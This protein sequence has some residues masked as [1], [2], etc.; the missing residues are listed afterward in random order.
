MLKAGSVQ[1]GEHTAMIEDFVKY[2]PS[3]LQHKSGMVFY[4]GRTAFSGHRKLYVLG[5]NP[6]G[7][8]AKQANETVAWHTS[9]VLREKPDKWSEY[10]DERWQGKPR[11]KHGMQPR[12]LHLLKNLELEP[13]EVPSSNL[14]FERSRKASDIALLQLAEVCWPFHGAVIKQLQPR[15]ILCLG[16]DVGKFVRKKT[17]AVDQID[18]LVETNNRNRKSI[19]FANHEG[20]KV[21]QVTH[22]SWVDW[23]NP[24]ADPSELV[25]RE[26]RP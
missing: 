24:K 9:M 5:L 22:P 12:I 21:V 8:P 1:L 26:L 13:G 19:C 11:G 7:N 17:C 3:K 16:K 25:C 4:S 2:I 15:V 18:S 6:G 10:S 14:V 20:L 23:K